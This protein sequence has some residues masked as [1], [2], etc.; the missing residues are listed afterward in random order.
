MSQNNDVYLT[1]SA[2]IGCDE[3]RKNV[4]RSIIIRANDTQIDI[5]PVGILLVI[6]DL[7][8]LYLALCMMLHIT[9]KK[10]DNTYI[11]NVNNISST[12]KEDEKS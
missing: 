2:S 9:R 4:N 8:F 11:Y 5:R 6:S 1:L 12:L 10:Q 7:F 3:P